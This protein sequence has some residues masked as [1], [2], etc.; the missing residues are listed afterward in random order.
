MTCGFIFGPGK[1]SLPIGSSPQNRKLVNVFNVVTTIPEP[2]TG[3]LLTL[4]LV[5]LAT[6]RGR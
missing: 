3:L 2:G 5:G 1:T 4:G 6:R